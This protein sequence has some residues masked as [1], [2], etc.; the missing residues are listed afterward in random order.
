MHS[1][2]DTAISPH[3]SYRSRMTQQPGDGLAGRSACRRAGG[4]PARSQWRQEPPGRN[5][6]SGSRCC[7]VCASP[8]GS[9]QPAS[10]GQA[11][12]AQ[13]STRRREACAAGATRRRRGHG[14]SRETH[15]CMVGAGRERGRH[16]R[17]GTA[18]GCSGRRVTFMTSSQLCMLPALLASIRPPAHAL[19]VTHVLM[20]HAAPHA[21][22]CP[23]DIVKSSPAA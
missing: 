6:P 12:G 10:R 18:R 21:W 22:R 2:C 14:A 17:C 15:R 9:V 23:V 1:M 5:D 19:G 20:Y 7:S 16:H 4:A 3:A 8:T 11:P 13:P